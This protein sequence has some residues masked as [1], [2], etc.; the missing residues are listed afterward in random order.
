MDNYYTVYIDGEFHADFDNF[1]D[2]KKRGV[3]LKKEWTDEINH[4]FPVITI[5]EVKQIDVF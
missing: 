1:D 5:Y 4:Y 2:A 3:I